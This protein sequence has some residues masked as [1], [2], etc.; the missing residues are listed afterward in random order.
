[1][2]KILRN[3]RRLGCDGRVRYANSDRRGGEAC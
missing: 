3:M 2:T 1:M